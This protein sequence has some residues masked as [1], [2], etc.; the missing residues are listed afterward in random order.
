MTTFDV[1]NIQQLKTMS[2]QYISHCE[3]LRIAKQAYDAGSYSTSFEL[4]ESLVHYIVS[5]KAAQELSPTHLKELREGI[6]QS[7]AQ[8]TTCK[9]EALW[10]E[11]SEL[12]ESVR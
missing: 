6:K 5:S 1:C 12:Y 11:A 3:T 8:F 7:L 10:E 2:E 9:D 4:L